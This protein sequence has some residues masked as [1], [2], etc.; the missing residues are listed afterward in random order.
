MMATAI[1][2]KFCSS[3]KETL[4]ISAFSEAK[5]YADG[6]RGQCKPC[7]ARYT[8]AYR[9]RTGW[10]PKTRPQRMDGEANRK[11]KMHRKYGISVEEYDEMLAGQ[12]GKCAICNRSETIARRLAVDH[13]HATR[14]VRGLL[15]YKCNTAIGLFG[16]DPKVVR[17]AAVYLEV[18]QAIT[19]CTVDVLAAEAGNG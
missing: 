9:E 12:G 11:R 2:S 10:K 6:Y 4:P 16:D 5:T 8:I 15:C 14:R 13:C 19:S 1:Q 17:S 3:C 18:D 7:R